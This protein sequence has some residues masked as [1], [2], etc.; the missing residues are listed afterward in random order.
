MIYLLLFTL[1]IIVL[2]R[3]SRAVNLRFLNT[4]PMLFYVVL[5]LPG[6]F[7]HELSHWLAAK[8]LFVRVGKFSLKPE[9]REKEVVLGSVAIEQTNIVKRLLIGA[10]PVIFGLMLILSVVYLVVAH[11]LA[12]GWKAVAVLGYLVFVIGNTMFSSRKDMEGA[13]KVVLFIA[14]LVVAAYFLGLKVN[15][16]LETDVFRHASLY[17][18]VPIAIDSVILLALSLMRGR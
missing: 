5:F 3:L 17:L 15:V 8:L 14:V 6:T 7:L 16:E 9:K 12:V 13:W 18:L 11:E 10:A 4:L 1:E 2:W